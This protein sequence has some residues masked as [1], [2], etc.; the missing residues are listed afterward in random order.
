MGGEPTINYK[1]KGFNHIRIIH[2]VGF[3]A[4]IKTTNHIEANC[5]IK[6]YCIFDKG[7]NSE[8]MNRLRKRSIEGNW[9]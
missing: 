7:F 9:L 8:I 6:N 5:T 1:I 2:E 3:G 4:G